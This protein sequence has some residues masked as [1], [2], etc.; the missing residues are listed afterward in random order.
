MSK[1]PHP[2]T[3]PT[4]QAQAPQPDPANQGSLKPH[5]SDP[6]LY[7]EE[8]EAKE[9]HNKFIALIDA[10]LTPELVRK[11]AHYLNT[12]NVQE[13]PALPNA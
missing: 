10:G 1:H 2:M 5:G 8:R 4:T 3:E 7:P 9:L 11:V 6:Q 13:P 12:I